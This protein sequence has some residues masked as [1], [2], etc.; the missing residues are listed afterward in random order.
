MF[1]FVHKH[2]LVLQIFLGL[3][4]ITFATWGIESYTRFRGGADTNATVN[5]LTITQR[6]FEAELRR[7]QEQLGRMLGGNF[8]PAGLERA[9]A[10]PA[11]PGSPV[12][13]PPPPSG[14]P[15]TRL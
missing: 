3:I 4:A 15:K 1:D 2:K 5:G 12:R 8:E 11:L 9:E 13:E 7:Q 6:E 14:A 10:R